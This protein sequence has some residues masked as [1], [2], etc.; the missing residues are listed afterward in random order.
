MTHL[1]VSHG[2]TEWGGEVEADD[3]TAAQ[4]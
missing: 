1:A 4:P 3:Y 2:P